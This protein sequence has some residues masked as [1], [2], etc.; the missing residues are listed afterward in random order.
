MLVGFFLLWFNLTD[1][2]INLN[3]LTVWDVG[4]VLEA[5]LYVGNPDWL[6]ALSVA[7]VWKFLLFVGTESPAEEGE[8]V[9]AG[10]DA[11]APQ[12]PVEENKTLH[13]YAQISSLCQF[14]FLSLIAW[15][16]VETVLGPA[17]PSSRLPDSGSAAVPEYGLTGVEALD[18]LL[19]ETAQEP[20]LLVM[21]Q[22]AWADNGVSIQTTP[23][24]AMAELCG[25]GVT[26][27]GHK[28][29][30]LLPALLQRVV[31]WQAPVY[32]FFSS[33][34]FGDAASLWLG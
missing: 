17:T 33:A 18:E 6:G 20:G 1:I 16:R 30:T 32:S 14:L 19:K 8:K 27:F 7:A 4:S 3:R 24:T 11:T 12:K 9:E 5:V 21:W 2:A 23:V 13:I 10:D 34:F 28:T 26:D 22:A 31:E 29:G 15:C 25:R